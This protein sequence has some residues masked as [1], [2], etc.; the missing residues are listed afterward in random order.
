MAVMLDEELAALKR[1]VTDRYEASG[2]P[3]DVVRTLDA[4][5]ERVLEHVDAIATGEGIDE[6]DHEILRV[7]AILHDAA[8]A[9]THLM[10][11]NEAGA[12]IAGEKLLELG[13]DESFI[14]EVQRG[15]ECHMGPFPFIEEEARKYAERTGVHLHFPKPLTS[16][17]KLFYDA[18]MLAL[19]DVEGIEKVVMLRST[20]AEFL[21][22]DEAVAARDGSTAR[23]AAY[24][25]AM[26]SVRRAADT[27]HSATAKQIAEQLVAKAQQHID[28]HLA[29]EASAASHPA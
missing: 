9:D 22:E 20:T 1:F 11:H 14:H 24:A 25:S 29:A 5:N 19:I 23:A 3:P 10:L 28:T 6:R 21:A 8:K 26:E 15:I 12:R 16:V 27:L 18:D 13:K 7:I 4:H 17:D 2:K